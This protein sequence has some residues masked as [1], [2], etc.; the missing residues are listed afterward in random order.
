VP[1]WESSPTAARSR[2]RRS[3]GHSTSRAS[4]RSSHRS[5]WCMAGRTPLRSSS[6]RRRWLADHGGRCSSARTPASACRR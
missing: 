2:P 3:T 4:G 1:G 6:G 5:W